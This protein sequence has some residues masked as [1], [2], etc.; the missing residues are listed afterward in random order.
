MAETKQSNGNQKLH[1]Q[2]INK[3]LQQDKDRINIIVQAAN[4]TISQSQ[5]ASALGVSDRQVRNLIK[6]TS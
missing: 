2:L 4:R 6:T 5:A 3:R 1:E